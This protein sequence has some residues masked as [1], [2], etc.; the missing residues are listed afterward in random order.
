MNTALLYLLLTPILASPLDEGAAVELRY[1]GTLEPAGRDASGVP[2][3]RYSFYNLLTRSETGGHDLAFVME[4]RGGGS[5]FWPERIGTMKLDRSNTPGG[6]QRIKVLYEHNETLYPLQ[7][8]QPLFEFANQID[9]GATWTSGRNQYK[10]GST[11][12]IGNYTCREILVSSNFGHA[13]TIWVDVESALVVKAEQRVVVGQGEIYKLSTELKSAQAIDADRLSVLNLSLQSL[14]T[15]KETLKRKTDDTRTDFNPGHVK[16]ISEG[17]EALE[18]N[19]DATPFSKLVSS[20]R[21]DLK[22]Q[23]ERSAGVETLVKRYVGQKASKFKLKS[24]TG[25]TIDSKEYEGKIVLLH[26]WKYNDEP[27][28]EPY[29]QVGYLDFLNSRREKMD[30]KIYGVAIDPRLTDKST[31]SSAIRDVRKLTRFMNLG[32]SVTADDGTLLRQ[33]GD[34][35]RV[36]A[37]LPLW[38]LIDPDGKIAH[39]KVGFYEI[40]RDQGL[41]DLDLEII[42]LVREFR[43]KKSEK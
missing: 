35:R 28:R 16:L 5:W 7:V 3:K 33:F 10:V 22:L 31:Y 2:V 11:K 30:V 39:Y 41:R 42:M 32:Y 8:Q 23:L 25:R 1:S 20:I 34:P 21:R 24:L 9:D 26:F 6:T 38:V 27:L 14:L 18:K 37:E 15:L 43:A 13:H 36:G 4:E 17:I 12:K 40:N 29:G 19:S